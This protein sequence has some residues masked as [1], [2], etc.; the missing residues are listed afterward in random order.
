MQ[1]FVSSV[2]PRGVRPELLEES[3][4]APP[5]CRGP[6]PLA[7]PTPRSEP[8][9]RRLDDVDFPR[10]EESGVRRLLVVSFAWPGTMKE[11]PL[12]NCERR[13]LLRAIEEKKVRGIGGFG[14]RLG[15]PAGWIPV[16]REFVVNLACG[17][18]VMWTR[19]V[20]CVNSARYPSLRPVFYSAQFL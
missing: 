1:A 2:K 9:R 13:F 12:S 10:R 4:T 3:C 16:A 14:C 20:P 15:L 8:A 17:V 18:V 7:P 19:V 6:R 5:G 11:T